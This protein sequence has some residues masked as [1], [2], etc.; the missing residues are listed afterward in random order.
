M[1]G[2][3]EKIFKD[4]PKTAN[5]HIRFSGIAE[6]CFSHFFGSGGRQLCKT[7]AYHIL[8]GC[9]ACGSSQTEEDFY[10]KWH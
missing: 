4:S 7:V 3:F 9:P 10:E 8:A 6:K 5:L 1:A 2:C